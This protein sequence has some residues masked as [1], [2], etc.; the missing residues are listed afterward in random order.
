MANDIESNYFF[1]NWLQTIFFISIYWEANYFFSKKINAP[2]PQIF[3]WLLP[4]M[5][6]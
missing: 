1:P 5:D 6:G 4:N 3:K 2:T